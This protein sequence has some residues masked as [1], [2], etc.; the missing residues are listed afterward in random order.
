MWA[1]L[2]LTG[3]DLGRR[4]P[5]SQE[6]WR[7][8]AA[9]ACRWQRA[10]ALAPL[11]VGWWKS[12]AAV[13]IAAVGALAAA[14][15][16]G[17]ATAATL[18][19][20]DCRAEAPWLP[21]RRLQAGCGAALRITGWPSRTARGWSAPGVL[22]ALGDTLRGD[23]EAFP[24]LGDGVMLKGDGELPRLW[25]MVTGHL[26]V[27]APAGPA[28][29]GG[30][31]P[32]AHARAR[33]LVWQGELEAAAVAGGGG[34]LDAGA[35]RVLEPV[36]SA[37]LERLDVLLPARESVL[38]GSI[39]LGE[40]DPSGRDLRDPFARLGLS[41]LFAVSGLH[42]GLVGALALL[43]LR[44]F[45]AGP[46]LRGL[47]LG[48]LLPLY[49]VLT[50]LA[51]SALRA[52]G[53]GLLAVA[54]VAA[55]R[56][57]DALRSLAL[58]L[59]AAVVWQP[60]CL[61]DPGVRLSYLAAGGIV[62][63]LRLADGLSGARRSVRAV[64]GPLLVSLGASWATLPATAATFG[65]IHPW[66][67]LVNLI[68]VPVFAGAVWAVAAALLVPWPW[69]AQAAA[70]LGWLL[71]RLLSAASSALDA[72]GD[73]RVGLP[74]WTAVSMFLFAA[75]SLL[76][77]TA[78]RSRP[79]PWLR[80]A[81][82]AG[83]LACAAGLTQTGRAVRPGTM[84]VLQADIGQ[85]DAAVFVFPDRSAVLVDT[86]SAWP[87]G[88]AYERVLDPWLRREGVRRFAVA[89]LTHGHDDHDGGAA[90][91]LA[92]RTVGAWVC[93]GAAAV[94]AGA[95]SVI[96][97]RPGAIVHAAGG[98][99]LLC[100]A[101][102]PDGGTAADEN[103]RSVVLA[104][105]R[106][107]QPVGLWMGDLEVAGE[108]DLLARGELGVPAGLD[109]L[110][111]GHHGSRTSSGAALLGAAPPRLVLI[112]CGVENSHGHPSHGPFVANGE[113]LPILRTDLCGS[114]LLRWPESAP[115]AVAAT[116][117]ARPAALLDTGGGAAYHPRVA[118]P[119]LPDRP[120]AT[121]Q[122]NRETHVQPAQ[123]GRSRPEARPSG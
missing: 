57:H 48:L 55:G 65:W 76:I 82:A 12:P 3:D 122:P 50:G 7:D 56:A 120:P 74:G 5:A 9:T 88:S 112:S 1:V 85:G 36:R 2:A 64:A 69:V 4:L 23:F 97:P 67:P 80:W 119:A 32:V 20:P 18:S 37:I 89:V 16:A 116:R 39:L 25:Q 95:D 91:V 90:D 31:S 26:V 71:V 22:V 118:P 115:F 63:A 17:R 83:A 29:F 98:W 52:T 94:P 46:N 40:R 113:T 107:G 114:V 14:T 41:H 102:V 106:A 77:A 79:P 103:D 47:W 72:L 62:G 81:A 87:G 59:W 45:A 8:A 70:A 10:G 100:L 117:G 54:G 78:L 68:A 108:A 13:P 99:D 121:V 27:G 43:L 33:G 96:C 101:A 6:P 86:G 11:L 111:A 105:R 44:P 109:V 75:G 123:H 93:G 84:T 104:L 15:A 21:S 60:E 28:V 34:L 51:G 38:M 92:G 66:A 19:R 49:A 35:G 30:F 110:K 24:R 73:G 61:G 42:V 53:L 58:L